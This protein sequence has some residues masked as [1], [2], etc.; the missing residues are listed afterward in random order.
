MLERFLHTDCH[1]CCQTIKNMARVTYAKKVLKISP[2]FDKKLFANVVTGV[3][4]CVQFYESQ[5]KVRNKTWATKSTKRQCTARR[6][7]SVQKLMYVIFFS[8]QGPPIQIAVPKG[9]DVTGYY[10]VTKY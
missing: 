8:T 10:I 9:R 2:N 4:T 6:T 7:M 5:R 3:E 1:I